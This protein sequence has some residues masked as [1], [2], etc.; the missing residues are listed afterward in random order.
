M[1]EID[2]CPLCDGD[3]LELFDEGAYIGHDLRNVI[4]AQCGL[5]LLSPRMDDN[6]LGAYYEGIYRAGR[7]GTAA[8]RPDQIR[9][10]AK[11]AEHLSSLLNG[12]L[13]KSTTHLDIGSAAG[14]LLLAMQ[15]RFNCN[16]FGIEPGDQQREHTRAAGLDVQASIYALEQYLGDRRI[17]VVTMGHVLEHISNPVAYLA[18][19]RESILAPEGLLL[20]EVPNLFVHTSFEPAHLFAFSKATLHLTLRKGGFRI[21]ATKVHGIPRRDPRGHYITVLAQV[22]SPAL[23]WTQPP[24]KISTIVVTKLRR[25]FSRSRAGL[26]VNHPVFVAQ[27]VVRRVARFTDRRS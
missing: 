16:S 11:R 19:L 6:E 12:H 14:E 13:A 23:P 24:R 18:H 17:D 22:Q 5:V 27:G 9:F 7:Y 1:I 10:E 15:R 3:K 8:P 2:R 20:V 4:C 26:L 21:L 25:H